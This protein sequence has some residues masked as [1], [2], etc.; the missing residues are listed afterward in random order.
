MSENEEF[1]ETK[2]DDAD[3]DEEKEELVDMEMESVDMD[4]SDEIQTFCELINV[5]R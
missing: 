5:N 2:D 3:E 1:P 4:L